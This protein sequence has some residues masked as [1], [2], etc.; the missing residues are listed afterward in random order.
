MVCF[1]GDFGVESKH[2]GLGTHAYMKSAWSFISLLEDCA[3]SS[4]GPAM[5]ADLFDLWAFDTGPRSAF[6]RLG[7][8]L[9]YVADRVLV[10]HPAVQPWKTSQMGKY[11]GLWVQST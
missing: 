10:C 11:A 5:G 1:N 3:W 4:H 6:S 8:P 2:S 9:E 7:L